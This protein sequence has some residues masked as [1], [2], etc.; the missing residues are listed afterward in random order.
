MIHHTCVPIPPKLTAR[1]TPTHMSDVENIVSQ[2]SPMSLNRT[3]VDP[4]KFAKTKEARDNQDTSTQTPRD[5]KS[6]KPI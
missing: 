4:K 5:I 6:K 3:P 2:T 1:V